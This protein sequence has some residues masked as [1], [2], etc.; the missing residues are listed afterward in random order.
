MEVILLEHIKKLGK[1]GDVVKVKDGYARNFLIPTKKALR[2]NNK[3]LEFFKKEKEKLESDNQEL[4]SQASQKAKIIENK[5]ITLIRQ[6]SETGQLYGSV[7]SR[8]IAKQLNDNENKFEHRNI[9][10]NTVIK[11]I[12][13]HIVKVVLHAEVEVSIKVNVAR[14]EEEASLQ[15]KSKPKSTRDKTIDADDI[16]ENKADLEKFVAIE[17]EELTSNNILDTKDDINY[18]KTNI[19]KGPVKNDIENDKKESGDLKK[20]ESDS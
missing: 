10:L 7:T 8:D 11:E 9:Q 18:K 5:S 12:G 14:T 13:M 16:F 19:E 6:A 2:A 1:L 4:K 20:P 17:N 15:E 3:N